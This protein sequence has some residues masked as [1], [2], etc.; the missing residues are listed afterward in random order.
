MKKI[1]AENFDELVLKSKK[2]VLVDFGAAWCGECRALEP[3]L[4]EVEKENNRVIFY[5]FDCDGNRDFVMEFG[6]MSIPA[7]LLFENGR[8]I[9]RK[10]GLM[11]KEELVGFLDL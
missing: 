6:I 2:K 1:T 3:L 8:V 10:I 9:K 11:S 7:L 4:K 5:S